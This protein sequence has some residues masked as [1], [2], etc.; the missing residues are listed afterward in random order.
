MT[1]QLVRTVFPLCMLVFLTKCSTRDKIVEFPATA[2]PAEEVGR[3]QGEI[4]LARKNQV[5]ILSPE[6]F[7]KADKALNTSI[8]LQ[9]EGKAPKDILYRVAVGRMHY[10]RAIA[11][12]DTSRANLA[13]VLR[14]R[15]A[16]VD[17]NAHRLY[18]KEFSEADENLRD[19][20]RQVERNNL[21]RVADQR[22][23][24][25]KEYMAV[26]LKAIQTQ[27]LSVARKAIETAKAEGA[28]N[29]ATRSLAIAEKAYSEANAFIIG[30]RYHKEGIK[31]R[32]DEATQKAQHLLK[33]TRSASSRENM[34]PEDVALLLHSEQQ[35]TSEE[36]RLLE[37]Q[38]ALT[39]NLESQTGELREDLKFNER[40]AKAQNE[41]DKDEATVYRQ[42][43]RLVI[44]LNSMAFPT[45]RST[46]RGT[47]FPLL[48]KVVKVIEEFENP[49]VTIEGHTDSTGTK[50]INKKLSNERA[51]AVSS[52]FVANGTLDESSIAAVGHG[53]DKPLAPN[54]SAVNRKQNRRVDVII[55]SQSH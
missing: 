41:F 34:S 17:V 54:N 44:R 36:T 3:L 42:G 47:D 38:Q 24:L 2:D 53:S 43:N 1:R 23:S 51:Q 28:R 8:E 12:A 45:N 21:D 18:N 48:A 25:Q 19:A 13:E 5:D 15:Q 50:A 35:K 39:Q 30:N 29:I 27:N 11:Y 9:R 6:E 31:I 22:L 14:A 33:I 52:Y 40:F 37:Q 46:L 55:T 10:N 16:A 20:T 32:S 49:Q 26:E 7:T 4:Q